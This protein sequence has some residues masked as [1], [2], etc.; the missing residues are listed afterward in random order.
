LGGFSG[1]ALGPYHCP[2]CQKRLG[3]L[4]IRDITLHEDVINKVMGVEEQNDSA[5]ETNRIA[6]VA[7]WFKWEN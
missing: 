6:R 2:G 4:G 5:E 1:R 7:N 3:K